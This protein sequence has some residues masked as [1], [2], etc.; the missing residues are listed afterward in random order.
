MTPLQFTG[1]K[2]PASGI[3]PDRCRLRVRAKINLYF[4]DRFSQ[5]IH[6]K[7]GPKQ[8][9]SIWHRANALIIIS[10]KPDFLNRS[11]NINN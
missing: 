4:Q 7:V 1:H 9:K 5:C 3:A 10:E 8:Y 2:I 11:Q 6:R